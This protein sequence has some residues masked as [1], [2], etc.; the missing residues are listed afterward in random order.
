MSISRI[1]DVLVGYIPY[2]QPLTS[3]NQLEITSEVGWLVDID[4]APYIHQLHR[5][6]PL[7]WTNPSSPW[8]VRSCWGG[9]TYPWQ[10]QGWW[11]PSPWD[12]NH[13]GL[14]TWTLGVVCWDI[15]MRNDP[16]RWV[17]EPVQPLLPM[18]NVT[19]WGCTSKYLASTNRWLTARTN[20][21]RIFWMAWW[22]LTNHELLWTTL[23]H[24]Y[25]PWLLT[26]ISGKPWFSTLG[27]NG[28]WFISGSIPRLRSW[29]IMVNHGSY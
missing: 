18:V 28:Q 4:P 20:S 2:Y 29:L 24:H 21:T 23:K 9:F 16:L 19:P 6:W 25:E 1:L 11:W 14:I 12:A 22:A 26:I 8:P 10:A 27:F 17:N 13:D 7:L 5:H 15:T 3:C